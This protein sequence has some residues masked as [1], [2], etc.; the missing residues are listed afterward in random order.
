MDYVQSMRDII[1][2]YG[3]APSE[4]FTIYFETLGSGSYQIYFLYLVRE[5]LFS[6]RK[7]S[8]LFI[9]KLRK[10]G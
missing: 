4:Y 7:D 8:G 5:I 6:T 3:C 9:P 2:A 1:N 10:D